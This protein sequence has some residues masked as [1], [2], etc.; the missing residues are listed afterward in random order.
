LIYRS[1][2]STGLSVSVVGLGCSHL[3][4]Q[5]RTRTRAEL[6]RLL[7][8]AV[9]RGITFFDTADV[10]MAGESERLLGEFLARHRERVVV[11]TKVGF[12]SLLPEAL[13]ARARPYLWSLTRRGAAISGLPRR[14]RGWLRRADYSAAYLRGA[15]EASLTRLRTDRIDLLQL[16]SPTAAALDRDGALET[17]EHLTAQG[18]IR[19]YGLAFGTA[20]QALSAVRDGG[21]STLQVPVSSGAPAAIHDVLAWAQQRA[22]GVIANQPL[23]GGALLHDRAASARRGAQSTVAQAAIRFVASLPGVSTVIV[24]TTSTT[25]VDEAIAAV[26]GP[27]LTHHELTSSHGEDRR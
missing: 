21:V 10:Y 22:I 17:L 24:G 3:G 6:V 4:A 9:E 11:A 1:L 5:R 20:A 19:F 13:L 15:V 18:K 12:S 16:H 14:V 25:H 7:E 23:R 8:H 26:D 2:G 27:S